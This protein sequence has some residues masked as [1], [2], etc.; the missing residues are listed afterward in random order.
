MLL[1]CCGGGSLKLELLFGLARRG[2]TGSFYAK[3]SAIIILQI[4]ANGLRSLQS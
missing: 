1:L 3:Y 2:V 4:N